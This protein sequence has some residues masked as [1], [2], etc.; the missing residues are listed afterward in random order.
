MDT[1]PQTTIIVAEGKNPILAFVLILIAGPL[2]FLYVSVMGGILQTVF[3][4][5]FFVV[6]LGFG[7][8]VL[9]FLNIVLACI[10][11]VMAGAQNRRVREGLAV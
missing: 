6:T 10:G 9:A 4:A 11:Y 7:A 5:I 2:G 3:Y 1:H 8:I